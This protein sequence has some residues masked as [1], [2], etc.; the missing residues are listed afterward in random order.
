MCWNAYC[1]N[2]TIGLPISAKPTALVP[3]FMLPS[4]IVVYFCSDISLISIF[5]RIGIMAK[6]VKVW[7]YRYTHTCVVSVKRLISSLLYGI[8]IYFPTIRNQCLDCGI[9][10]R[11]S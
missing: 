7:A 2:T 8:D 10:C 6:M 5:V 3:V 1:G 9:T 4:V 11:R